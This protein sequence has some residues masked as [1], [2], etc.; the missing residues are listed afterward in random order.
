MVGRREPGDVADREPAPVLD[1]HLPGPQGA[2]TTR[3]SASC[4]SRLTTIA[5][6]LSPRRTATNRDPSRETRNDFTS[7]PVTPPMSIS[8]VTPSRR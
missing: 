4:S 2:S 6:S 1:V 8:S 3:P 5:S 7:S